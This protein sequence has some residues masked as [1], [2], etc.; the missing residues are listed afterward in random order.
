MEPA[1]STE[2]IDVATLE[3][4]NLAAEQI[5][6]IR[7]R[8]LKES[9]NLFPPCSSSSSDGEYDRDSADSEWGRYFYASCL[10][11]ESEDD[12]DSDFGCL[13][14]VPTPEPHV[15]QHRGLVVP[16]LMDFSLDGFSVDDHEEPTCNLITWFCLPDGDSGR[17]YCFTYQFEVPY[18]VAV[19]DKL[20]LGWLLDR[21][22]KY[23][24]EFTFPYQCLEVTEVAIGA[25]DDKKDGVTE[26]SDRSTSVSIL[27]SEK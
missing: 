23:R 20:V 22:S 2:N 24:F 21:C 7:K 27:S 1:Q 4:L 14:Y 3:D 8:L 16:G 25:E 13:Y 11:H 5:D 10:F 6:L 15:V 12:T 17:N 18:A 19:T 9:G 26:N